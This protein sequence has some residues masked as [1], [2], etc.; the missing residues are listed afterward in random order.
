MTRIKPHIDYLWERELKRLGDES[1][2][3]RVDIIGKSDATLDSDI[4]IIIDKLI[5]C[6]AMPQVKMAREFLTE[7]LERME[8]YGD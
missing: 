4:D 3:D 2:I 7:R 6:R 5:E 8:I 1:V